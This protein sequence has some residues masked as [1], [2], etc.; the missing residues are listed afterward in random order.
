[1]KRRTFNV[2]EA[3]PLE[4]LLAEA[5]PCSP[6]EAQA[7]VRRGAA[8]VDGRRAQAAALVQ[9]GARVLVVLEEAGTSA[10]AAAPAATALVLLHED[11]DVLAVDKPAGVTAQPTPSRTG[12]SLLDQ[13]SAYLGRTAGLV[14][15]LDRETSGV[16]VFGKHPEATSRLAAAFRE[17][18]AAKVYLA[19]TA[20]G[21]P[22]EGTITLPLSRDPS[23]P[24]RWRASAQ[25]NGL[26][27]ETRY[28]RLFEVEVSGVALFP[29]TGRTHQLRAHLA[30]IGHPIVG[31]ALYGGP[32]GPRCLL[33]ARRLEVLGLRLEAP[34]P[35]DLAAL[36]HAGEWE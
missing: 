26:S 36:R 19:A 13:A 2:A 24:G 4:R 31:D 1:M 32:P 7:L 35:G 15:R 16:T 30:A 25:A 34:V 5:L 8:Y 9:P 28:R 29:R 23:R 3:A 27:A 18:R 6:R 17:G 10:W 20:P 33:H 14:H 21:L 11:E 12:A 22:A